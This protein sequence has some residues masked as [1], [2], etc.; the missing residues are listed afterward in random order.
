VGSRRLLLWSRVLFLA[1][2]LGA[3]LA[4]GDY[5]F[6]ALFALYGAALWSTW[7]VTTP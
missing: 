5:V 2:A 1:V 6:R 7:W 3:L 4:H